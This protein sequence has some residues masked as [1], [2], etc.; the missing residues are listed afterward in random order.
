M[1]PPEDPSLAI[2]R[3]MA[4]VTNAS[5]S[6]LDM[7]CLYS[8]SMN[9]QMKVDPDPST[10]QDTGTIVPPIGN[11]KTCPPLFSSQPATIMAA[12]RFMFLLL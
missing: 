4:R 10:A 6:S 11:E 2:A 9:P 12:R 3:L 8:A 7:S 1:R 5:A